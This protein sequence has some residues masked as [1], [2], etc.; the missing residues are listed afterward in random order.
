MKSLKI[1]NGTAG[2]PLQNANSRIVEGIP[3]T[4]L[5]S[6]F[7]FFLSVMLISTFAWSIEAT[8]GPSLTMDP[9]GVTPLAGVVELTTDV[10]TRVTLTISDGSDS[11]VREFAEFQTEHYLPILGLKPDN[12]YSVEVIVTDQ[13]DESLVLAPLLPAV[14]GP[15]PV[16]FPNINVLF[17]DSTKME[18][19]FTLLDKISRGGSTTPDGTLPIYTIIVDNAGDVVWY[20]T[21]G[22]G[23]MRQLSNGNLFYRVYRAVNVFEIDLLGNE[24][25]SVVLSVGLLHHDLFP[26]TNGTLLSL[27]SETVVV[28]GFPTSDANPNAP[29]QT[30]NIEDTPVVEFLSDGS[31]LNTWKLTDILDPTRIGFDS[32]DSRSVGLGFDWAHANAVLYD[33]RDDSIIVSVRHQDAVVKFS[34]STGNL[35]WILGNHD[36]WPPEFQ[37]FL[38]TPVG[39]P[40][41]WQYH[42]HAQMITSSG[43]LLLFDNGNYRA[44]P[45]DG[46][47][48]IPDDENYSRAVEYAIDKERMEV[49]QIWEYGAQIEQ[50][51]YSGSLSDA[52][53]MKNTGNVLITSSVT[54]WLG[55]VSS[56]SL[57]MGRSHA[58]IIE[59]DH[60]TPAE[61]VFEMAVF[62]T[63]PN[64]RIRLYRSERIPD[65]YPLDTDSDGVPDYQDNCVHT[66]NGVLLPDAGGNSQVDTDGDALGDA[67][68]PD[69]DNDGLTDAQEL[70]LGTD[71]LLVDTDSDGLSDL[72]EVSAGDPLTYDIGVDTDPND[73]DTD[74]DWIKDGVEVS[75]GTDPVDPADYPGN[76]DFNENLV[77]NAG[78]VVACTRVLMTAGYDMRCDAAPLDING[79]PMLDSNID[80]SDILIILQR[81]LGVR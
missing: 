8:L 28:D 67:C 34:R 33:P 2:S 39:A 62:N 44:S 48:P 4:K 40:F 38:L 17:S 81:A 15:L 16:D 69:D 3:F 70:A 10:S 6:V 49:R 46:R 32:L 24:K 19:G 11:W 72:S 55:G 13:A 25:Q 52:D 53:W 27:T 58:R 5:L 77:I 68:D 35:E 36:N 54:S 45:F 61:K 12:S 42:Q 26:T 7:L 9:N 73:D 47:V 65:L 59:V 76:G 30:A 64:S 75:R 63:T 80:V 56:G 57:G 18:P 21:L 29:T 20:S 74:D 37:P 60:N 71:P 78:D 41:E 22:A 23:V 14:T 79:A 31:L 50:N 51:Y 43:T 1:T 66:P